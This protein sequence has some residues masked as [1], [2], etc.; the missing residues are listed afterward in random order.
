MDQK[1]PRH[2]SFVSKYYL[3]AIAAYYPEKIFNE[4]ALVKSN[5]TSYSTIVT[6]R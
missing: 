3:K 5:I 6:I 2:F 1:Y 4:I